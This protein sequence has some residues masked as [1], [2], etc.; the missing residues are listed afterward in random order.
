MLRKLVDVIVVFGCE[1]C[2][3][4]YYF[5]TKKLDQIKEVESVSETDIFN[6]IVVDDF[7]DF[8]H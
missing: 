2:Y 5:K 7:V 1:Y 6:F 8:V 3:K 4:S